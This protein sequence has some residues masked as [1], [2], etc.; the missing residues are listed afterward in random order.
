MEKHEEYYT[1]LQNRIRHM[2]VD[3]HEEL[4]NIERLVHGNESAVLLLQWVRDAYQRVMENYE[5]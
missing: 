1:E 5:T 4:D 2:T 3:F